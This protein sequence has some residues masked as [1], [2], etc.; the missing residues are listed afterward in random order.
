MIPIARD[1]QLA[2]VFLIPSLRSFFDPQLAQACG[3]L[4]PGANMGLTNL[5]LCY[6]Y[7]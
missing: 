7:Y 3:L 4:K 5:E 2:L 6:L 1:P